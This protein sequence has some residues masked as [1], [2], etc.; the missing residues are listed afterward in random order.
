MMKIQNE[1]NK[2]YS[3]Q[4]H[5]YCIRISPII[6]NKHTNNEED[7]E[8]GE[9]TVMLFLRR[10]FLGQVHCYT[11][12]CSGYRCCKSSCWVDEFCTICAIYINKT[13]NEYIVM[14]VKIHLPVAEVYVLQDKIHFYHYEKSLRQQRHTCREW[15][16]IFTIMRN[17][18]RHTC[19]EWKHESP[20][21][22]MVFSGSH[23]HGVANFGQ[24]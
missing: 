4:N 16:H 11:L 2:Q 10:S 14:R 3:R 24:W 12:G 15:K 17:H 13:T 1:G 23:M 19:R 9:A 7:E 22:I 20:K 6:K 18:L 8:D 21:S 5:V